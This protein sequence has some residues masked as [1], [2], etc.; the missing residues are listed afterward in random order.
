SSTSTSTSST[1]LPTCDPTTCTNCVVSCDPVDCDLH[2]QSDNRDCVD[3]CNGD[4]T[5][6]NGCTAAVNA[7]AAG[8]EQ[9]F[10]DCIQQNCTS[11]IHCGIGCCSEGQQRCSGTCV[12]T[13]TDPSNCGNCGTVCESGTCTGG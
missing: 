2:C 6:L 10:A 7:C 3:G 9:E 8:C 12:D 1:T 13:S 5:C 4:P 11:A